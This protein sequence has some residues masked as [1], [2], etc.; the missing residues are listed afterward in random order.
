[1]KN[2]IYKKEKGSITLFVLISLLF[3][4]IVGM[5]LYISIS[6]KSVAQTAEILKIQSQY[7]VTEEEMEEMYIKTLENS[8][9]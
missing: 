8:N 7:E 1:M 3:F 6:N 2:K 9:P 5:S 4:L